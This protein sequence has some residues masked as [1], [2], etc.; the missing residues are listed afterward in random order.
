MTAGRYDA[1]AAGRD[2]IVT[3]R[4]TTVAAARQSDEPSRPP[5]VHRERRTV[6]ARTVRIRQLLTADP[7]GVKC[8]PSWP[9][10]GGRSRLGARPRRLRPGRHHARCRHPQRQR[11]RSSSAAGDERAWGDPSASGPRGALR[12]TDLVEPG[13]VDVMASLA[14]SYLEGASPLVEQRGAQG[15][16]PLEGAAAQPVTL[17]SPPAR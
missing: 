16:A 9:A 13:R 8:P 15:T 3:A 2:G 6:C 14:V 1:W 10:L 12:P 5:M 7:G 4:A 11:K 17:R